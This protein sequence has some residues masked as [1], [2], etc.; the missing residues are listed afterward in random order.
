[1]NNQSKKSSAM[2]SK[3]NSPRYIKTRS[4]GM[5]EDNTVDSHVLKNNLQEFYKNSKDKLL[6]LKSEIDLIESDN[7]RQKE[8]NNKLN[9]NYLELIQTNE[10]L[11]LRLKGMKEKMILANK[12]RTN[13]NN[14]I[15]DMKKDMESTSTEIETMKI[16]NNYK[17]KMIQNEIDHTNVVKQNNVESIRKKINHE[18]DIQENLNEKITEIKGEIEKYKDLIKELN[19][20]DSVRTK[21]LL[22]ET[23]E[24]TKFLSEL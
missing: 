10:A 6:K 21:G 22:K 5:R 17:I 16:D 9:L 12:N 15:R 1:M 18:E 2:N 24:M 3:K 23:A 8:E 13:L 7:E 14:Q 19:Q 4:S 20:H 11:G